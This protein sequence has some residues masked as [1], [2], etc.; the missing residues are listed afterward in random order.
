[1]TLIMGTPENTREDPDS[2]EIL[3]RR[4]HVVTLYSS[5]S[6]PF[7]YYASIK[8]LSS[9]SSSP[10]VKYVIKTIAFTGKFIDQTFHVL[11]CVRARAPLGRRPRVKNH[12]FHR[13]VV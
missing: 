11:E 8:Q 12:C 7:P 10:D 6:Q 9:V 13:N 2:C 3:T 4:S 1:M 5:G